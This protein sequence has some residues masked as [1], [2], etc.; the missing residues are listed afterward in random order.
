MIT[1]KKL[2]LST[3]FLRLARRSPAFLRTP[4]VPSDR[5][6]TGIVLM[7]SDA[8]YLDLTPGIGLAERGYTTLAAAPPAGTL[9][10]KM[11]ALGECIAHMRSLPGIR[12][13]I[14]FGHSGGASLISAYQAAAENGVGIFRGPEMLYPCPDIPTLQPADG[15]LIIDSNW[16]NGVMTLMSLDPC[17]TDEASGRNL[18]PSLN[19]VDPENGYDPKGSHYSEEFVTRFANAQGERMNRIVERAVERL[20][21]IEAGR[22]LFSDDE[23]FLIPGGSQAGPCNKLF[24]QDIRYLSHTKREHTLLHGDGGETTE[25]VRSLRLPMPC[26]ALSEALA[27]A[28][29]AR[30]VRTFLS[31]CC[32]VTDGFRYD[33]VDIYGV[34]FSRSFCNTPGNI[35]HIHAPILFL[36]L[37]GGYESMAAERIYDACPS[38]DKSIAYVE[39]ATHNFTPNHDAERVPGEFGD[40]EATMCDYI[41]R[42]L[43]A[44]R[45]GK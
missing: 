28:S 11:A 24:P 33:D 12:K 5:N 16:G 27:G 37:T 1:K 38:G 19:P 29:A 6:G 34:D 31:N 15:V 14:L 40:T 2:E 13:V 30:T 41:D 35:R 26:R 9:E 8:D 17:V 45:F 20:H 36:G 7:H 42:W 23:P 43:S 3:A 44:G 4:A 32:V 21:A 18:D 10:N 22:G 39:G 25:I